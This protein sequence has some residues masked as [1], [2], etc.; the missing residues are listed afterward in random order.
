MCC[1]RLA[2]N[3]GR[4]NRHMGTIAQLCPPISSQLRH[5]STIGKRAKQQY[6]LHM[7]AQYGELWPTN[8]WDLLASLGHPCKLTGFASC[9]P[10]CTDVAQRRST[11]LC[12]T[13]D[14]LVGWYTIYAFLWLLSLTPDRILPAAKFTLRLSLPFSYIR[15][16]TA[17]HSSSGRQ[18]N[19]VA[20]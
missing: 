1:T 4:K 2:E 16:V 17:R 19:F 9:L 11:K 13:L 6:L 15:S 8:G 3:T 10:Y 5:V 20:L 18:P 7:S 12:R 14:R